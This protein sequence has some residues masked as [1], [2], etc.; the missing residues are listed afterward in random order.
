MLCVVGVCV[1]VVTRVNPFAAADDDDAYVDVDVDV[2]AVGC[3]SG[4]YY[5]DCSH[6]HHG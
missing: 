5:Y 6:V 3:S 4:C 1:V 2:G